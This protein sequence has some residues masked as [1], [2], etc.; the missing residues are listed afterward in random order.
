VWVTEEDIARIAAH[1]GE[2][3]E[4][5]AQRNVRL[6]DGRL[7]LTEKWN[8][9]CVL[10]DSNRGCTVYPV[11][12]RQCRTY[13]FWRSVVATPQTWAEEAT[14]CAGIG[15]GEVVRGEEIQRMVDGL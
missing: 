4:A 11:R 15:Q 5:F 10:Y 14:S 1:R 2:T 9:E 3:A 12:P 7:S 13:P 8:G 6:I